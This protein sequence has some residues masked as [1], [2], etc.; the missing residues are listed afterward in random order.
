MNIEKNWNN[1]NTSAD[2]ELSALLREDSLSKLSSNSPLEK[3]KGALIMN[4]IWV[5]LICLGYIFIIT[6]FHFWQIQLL[7]GI[8]LAFTLWA[9]YTAFIQ[10]KKIN[11]TVASG[12]SLLQEM[13]RHH[14]SVTRWMKLQERIGLFIYPFSAAGGFLFG[15][16]LNSGKSVEAFMSKPSVFVILFITI[17]VLVPAGYFGAKRMFKKGFGKHLDALNENIKALEEEK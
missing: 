10:Y 3:I 4:M 17:A 1:I 5:S 13:K 8:V 14:Q 7:I 11:T 9:L 12:N 6:Y 2:D 15:G 16:V